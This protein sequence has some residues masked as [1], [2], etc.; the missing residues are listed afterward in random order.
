MPQP[1]IIKICLKITYLKF[2]SNLPGKTSH[3]WTWKYKFELAVLR[4]EGLQSWESHYSDIIMGMMASQITSLTIVYSTIDSGT[5]ER[6]DQSCTSLAFE[7]GIHR[8]SVNSQHKWPVTWKMFSFDDVIWVLRELFWYTELLW[9]FV[10][11]LM[12]FFP[13]QVS[14]LVS[15]F[16]KYISDCMYITF[17]TH[18]M[19]IFWVW[20]WSSL[21]IKCLKIL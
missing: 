10:M 8:W 15:W 13:F 2:H 19:C 12:V 16:S 14:A 11:Y 20:T 17:S 7:R 4:P 6:K 1:S 21:Q 3:G 5:D 9:Y 18:S